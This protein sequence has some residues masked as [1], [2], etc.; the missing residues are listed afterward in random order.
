MFMLFSIDDL[1]FLIYLQILANSKRFPMF[2][3][4]FFEREF[5]DDVKRP[6]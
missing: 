1:L 2:I 3:E 5:L 4:M 6:M